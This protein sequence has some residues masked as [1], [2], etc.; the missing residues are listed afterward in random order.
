MPIRVICPEC[1]TVYNIAEN[2]RGKKFRCRSCEAHVSVPNGP[3]AKAPVEKVT[4]SPPRVRNQPEE[5]EDLPLR[6]K[7]R[8]GKARRD[9]RQSGSFF[10]MLPVWAWLAIIGG[11]GLVLIAGCLGGGFLLW[12]GMSSSASNEPA[13]HPIAAKRTADQLVGEFSTN[14]TAAKENYDGK[15]IEITGFVAKVDGSEVIFAYGGQD[16]VLERIQCRFASGQKQKLKTVLGQP[17]TVQG[18]FAGKQYAYIVFED[19]V[20]IQ[21]GPAGGPDKGFDDDE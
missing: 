20:L 2:L 8:D 21:S 19:C 3:P 14:Y 17:I 7:K 5:A 10:E 13:T 1:E 4:A 16:A 15:W 12:R 18:K 11:G 6:K 9:K